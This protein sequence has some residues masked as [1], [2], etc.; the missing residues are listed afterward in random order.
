LGQF[1]IRKLPRSVPLGKARP[2]AAASFWVCDGSCLLSDSRMMPAGQRR[3]RVHEGEHARQRIFGEAQQQ[4][5]RPALL[6]QQRQQHSQAKQRQAGEGDNEC[7][8]LSRHKF[9][10]TNERSREGTGRDDARHGGP[11]QKQVRFSEAEAR[12]RQQRDIAGL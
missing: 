9:R 12:R 7:A 11:Q 1:T 6:P 2:P 8:S 4:Q 10:R 5:H 3:R